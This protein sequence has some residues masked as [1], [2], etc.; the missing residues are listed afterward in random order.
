[1]GFWIFDKIFTFLSN[2][3]PEPYVLNVREAHARGET[4]LPQLYGDY[5]PRPLTD[6]DRMGRWSLGWRPKKEANL[7]T[8]EIIERSKSKRPDEYITEEEKKKK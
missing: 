1:M 8:K 5:G 3:M 2:C 7:T 6:I 4:Y